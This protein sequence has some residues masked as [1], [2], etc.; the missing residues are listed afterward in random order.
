MK[1]LLKQL[2]RMM[3]MLLPYYFFSKET[4]AQCVVVTLTRSLLP[5]TVNFYR[6][7]SRMANW[8][9]RR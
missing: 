3:M 8:P 7:P 4:T 1:V 2:T 5:T 6:K 9:L